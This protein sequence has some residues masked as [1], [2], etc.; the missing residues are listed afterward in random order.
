M[1]RIVV[2]VKKNVLQMKK[3]KQA[4]LPLRLEPA[5]KTTIKRLARKSKIS[6]SEWIRRVIEK[7]IK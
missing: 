5:M 2:F 1:N 7:E 3:N 4:Y 6:V